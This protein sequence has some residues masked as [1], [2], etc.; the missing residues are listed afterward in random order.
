[1][2]FHL[3]EAE[4]GVE[5]SS[6]EPILVALL[7]ENFIRDLMPPRC[8]SIIV[9]LDPVLSFMYILSPGSFYCSSFFPISYLSS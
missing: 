7:L 1:M 3:Q 4:K 6:S 5:I 2:K 8:F 9:F